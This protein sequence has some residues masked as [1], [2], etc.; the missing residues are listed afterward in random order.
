VFLKPYPVLPVEQDTIALPG[1]NRVKV[2][3][4]RFQPCRRPNKRP[5]K[6]N[7]EIVPKR[8]SIT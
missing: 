6:S 5:V 8:R 3:G 2:S 4:V 1:V 7:K